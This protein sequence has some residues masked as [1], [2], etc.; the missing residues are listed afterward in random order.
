MKRKYLHA[1]IIML[2]MPVLAGAQALK[3]SYF[4]DYSMNRHRMNPAF[5]P[6]ADYFQLAGIGNI[7][8]GAATNLDVPALFYPQN[9]KLLTFLH[10]DVSVDQ[11]SKALPQ[12]PHL[13]AD[14]SATLL[15]FGFFTKQKSYW[16]FD[17]DMRVMADIDIPRD[18]FMFLKKGTGTSGESFNIG[19]VNAYASGSLQAAL[20]YSR[21]IVKGLRAGVKARFIAPVAY[22]GLNIENFRL[23]TGRDKW[24][25]TTEGYANAAMRGMDLS[26]PQGETMPAFGFDGERM[27]SE[28]VLAGWGYSF[29]FGVEYRYE[30]EGAFNGFAVSAA[31][32]DLGQIFYAQDA[33]HSYSSKGS[34]DWMGFQNV[35]PDNA[36]FEEAL[37]DLTSKAE[38]LLNFNEVKSEGALMRSSMPRVYA[39]ID[40]PFL[41]NKM[42]V[43]LLYSARFSH[44]YARHE[45][46]AS[47]NL[48]PCKWFG[49][50]VNW[51][52]LNTI[53][54]FGWILEFTP[55][56]GPAF[57][58][59]GDYFPMTFAKAPILGNTQIPLGLRLNVNFGIAFTLGTKYGR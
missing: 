50:G 22:M 59:G 54:T 44:S 16:T 49:L 7:G 53:Q 46:T 56:V 32:T 38:G 29:D 28:G 30:M 58:I 43:G 18:L 34:V 4:L 25:I 2:M 33:V 55:K 48:K 36:D 41:W 39:G 52:F 27:L 51:S 17:L 13:D 47:Y 3:G 57:Y 14:V 45:L 20:G 8:A 35:A 9:G 10:K 12:Y 19:N 6:R 15:S 11:F 37:D 23:T 26:I 42:S 21:D 24:T 40:V 1:A 31:V 5:T